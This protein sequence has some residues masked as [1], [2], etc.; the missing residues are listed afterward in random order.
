MKQKEVL[1]LNPINDAYLRFIGMD[2]KKYKSISLDCE[3]CGRNNFEL[4]MNKG[5]IGHK[6][7]YGPVSI[8]QCRYCG[9]VMM[10]PRFEAQFYIDYYKE[11]YKDIGAF[12]GEKPRPGFL[13]R[14]IE[15]GAAVLDFLEKNRSIPKGKMLDL[16]CSFGGAMIPFRDR[17][18]SVHGIDPEEAS[19]EYGQ[20]ELDLPIVYGF[21]ERLPFESN[22]MDL[23]I[24]LGALEHVHDFH[25]TMMELFRVRRLSFYS[26]AK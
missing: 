4:I 11:F 12:G 14:Q 5:K 19:V 26:H 7:E 18:W 9:H 6:G 10:N 20:K 3:I 13:E 1:K 15:R 2:G 21:A 16:G 25:E 8:V 22:E 24:S 23:V 17:G